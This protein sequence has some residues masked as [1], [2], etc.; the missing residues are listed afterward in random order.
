MAIDCRP[1]ASPLHNT[2][3]VVFIVADGRSIVTV[4]G[5]AKHS[6]IKIVVDSDRLSPECES[7]YIIHISYKSIRI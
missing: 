4:V 6:D 1:N 2:Y 3:F 7:P 5:R